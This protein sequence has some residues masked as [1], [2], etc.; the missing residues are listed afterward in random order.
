[1]I[2]F[3]NCKIN[4]GLK[5]TRKRADG[6]HD[7]E[8][9]FFPL[10]LTDVLEVI[11]D[12][13][14]N[15]ITFTQSGLDINGPAD[16]NLCIKAYRLLKKHFPD[17]PPTLM[18][19]HKAIPMGAGLGGGSSDGAY[20][21][22]LLNDKY[23]L[24]ADIEQLLEL[25]LQLGSDCP[26][27]ILNKPCIATGRGEIMEPIPLD[28]SAYRF[29]LVHPGIHISTAEA[30]SGITPAP[31]KMPL[32]EIIQLP[33]EDWKHH[34]VNDFEQSV[35]IKHPEL[36]EI[37]QSLYNAGAIYAS[38]SG[39]GSSFYGVFPKG[40]IDLNLDYTTSLL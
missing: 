39:S 21:L 23:N 22:R 40:E 7:L 15:D 4:L 12:Q 6:Y 8:T 14:G 20:A 10:P 35:F 18:H 3:P 1:M 29:A 26:F 19:L 16:A 13:K 28:L 32:K 9:V 34:L 37:K 5:I 17:L 31:N 30:F 25:A 11:E 33:I 38:M 2:V 27:F 36:E 24:G